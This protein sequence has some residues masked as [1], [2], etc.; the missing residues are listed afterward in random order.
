VYWCAR[1]LTNRFYIFEKNSQV[2]AADKP[3]ELE[4]EL[5][6]LEF[7]KVPTENVSHVQAQSYREVRHLVLSDDLSDIIIDIIN[8]SC[9]ATLVAWAK[10]AAFNP[11]ANRV[12]TC[13][14]LFSWPA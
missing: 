10:N 3:V 4:E 6:D 11:S 1:A 8:P 12:L 9:P 13:V 7:F 2:Y 14:T 5:W